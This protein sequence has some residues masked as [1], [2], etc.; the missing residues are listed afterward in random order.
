LGALGPIINLKRHVIRHQ[1]KW[2]KK[3]WNDMATF[4]QVIVKARKARD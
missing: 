2:G 1:S 3:G 4:G